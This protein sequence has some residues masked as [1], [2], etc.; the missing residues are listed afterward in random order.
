MTTNNT[1]ALI[2]AAVELMFLTEKSE[3]HNNISPELW[4]KLTRNRATLAA[5]IY[6]IEQQPTNTGDA[7]ARKDGDTGCRNSVCNPSPASNMQQP[8]GCHCRQS[9]TRGKYEQLQNNR[10]S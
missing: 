10:T 6:A 2:K 5:S 9:L 3:I 8:T 1:Q 4:E 7:P